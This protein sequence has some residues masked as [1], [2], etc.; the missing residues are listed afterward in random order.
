[1]STGSTVKLTFV[2][3]STSLEKANAR[4][5][6][7]SE[8]VSGR[9]KETSVQ[10]KH[11]RETLR[12]AGDAAT[13]FGGQMGATAIQAGYGLSAIKDLTRG[14]AGLARGMSAAKLVAGGFIG[15]ILA[16]GVAL[17]AHIDH[18][19]AM[20][21]VNR[22]AADTTDTV[23][24]SLQFL[25]QKIPGVNSLMNKARGVTR[26]WSDDAHGLTNALWGLEVQAI[27]TGNAAGVANAKVRELQSKNSAF[28]PYK[29]GYQFDTNNPGYQDMEYKR[30]MTPPKPAGGG[31]GS[32]GGGGGGAIRSAGKSAVDA[33][34]EAAAN[35][36]QARTSVAQAMGGILAAFAGHLEAGDAGTSVHQLNGT[37]ALE[38]GVSLIDKLRKQA[39]DTKR[40]AA[41]LR[42]LSKMGLS[43]G[44]LSDLVAGGLGSL[45]AADELLAG[46]ARSVSTANS[47][48]ASIG[49]SGQS[50]AAG[51]VNRN[52]TKK[53]RVQIDINVTGGEDALKKLIRKWIRTDGANSYGL[54][55]A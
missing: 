50:I 19:N 23:T 4:V 41:D 14:V 49:K 13:V 26:G 27:N 30:I 45:G 42:S 55:A 53:D 29:T 16:A 10:A 1:M 8:S 31:S 32:G 15:A 33:A 47:L 36:R 12:G 28:G 24:G 54:Q 38:G 5:I 11:M 37:M 52:L 39:A 6:A 46:G 9:L 48:N 3:D 20:N 18:T 44:L 35:L 7:S 51:E 17:S 21:E 22:T 40:L 43:K 2:G 25:T 34:K